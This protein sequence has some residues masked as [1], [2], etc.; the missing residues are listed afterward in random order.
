MPV[1]VAAQENHLPPAPVAQAAEAVRRAPVPAPADAP[2]PYPQ[3]D[4][5]YRARVGEDD[6]TMYAVLF[7]ANVTDGLASEAEVR[8]GYAMATA[9]GTTPRKMQNLLLDLALSVEVFPRPHY[10]QGPDR[11]AAL[12]AL[13]GLRVGFAPQHA[14]QV[15]D[16]ARTVQGADIAKFIAEELLVV[17][18]TTVNGYGAYLVGA[19]AVGGAAAKGAAIKAGGLGIAGTAK[20]GAVCLGW[21]GVGALACLWGVATLAEGVFTAGLDVPNRYDDVLEP[22]WFKDRRILDRILEG[23]VVGDSPAKMRREGRVQ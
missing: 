21:V 16:Y 23:V 2:P 9:H 8:R 6:S 20:A 12:G 4:T 7:A 11:R 3:R 10:M 19:K 14:A 13:M 22:K 18:A 15:V 17:A 1:A 5:F